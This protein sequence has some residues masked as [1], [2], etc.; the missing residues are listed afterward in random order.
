MEYNIVLENEFKKIKEKIEESNNIAIVG[1]NMPDGD[2]IGSMMALKIFFEYI[3]KKVYTF[4]KNISRK[5]QKTVN[6]DEILEK[7]PS[8]LNLSNIDICIY[9]D[10]PKIERADLEFKKLE[11]IKFKI[12]IDHHKGNNMF[13]DINAVS[14]MT[15]TT[16]I[17][18]LFIKYFLGEKYESFKKEK[19]YIDIMRCIMMGV[20]TDSGGFRHQNMNYLAFDIASEAM[21]ANVNLFDIYRINLIEKSETEFD[22]D[23][24]VRNNIEFFLDGKIAFIALKAEDEC[25]IKR[26]IGEDEAL[27]NI[28]K[29]YE[30]NLISIFI[31]EVD[32]GY[33]LSVR[34]N[35]PYSAFNT[36]KV[37]NGGG[38]EGAAGA[39]IEIANLVNLEKE[40]KEK[41]LKYI[42]EK[43]I[44]S[45]V[46]EI[47]S[48]DRYKIA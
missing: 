13:G 16:E 9:V 5:V 39:D 30:G 15:S 6:T 46:S 36:V 2:S 38:H 45:A 12:C 21:K 40:E 42:K 33:K 37:F 24:Y 48:K 11:N 29:E 43:I 4:G 27:V 47:E 44:Y 28:G 1:H 25:Y 41:I 26:N 23:K 7:I 18:Y 10:L 22:L 32:N 17:V 34:T 20:I 35:T 31:K 14:I 8:D 19:K 3:G